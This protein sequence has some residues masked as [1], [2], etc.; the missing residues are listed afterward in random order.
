MPSAEVDSA[1]VYAAG[2]SF[3]RDLRD[4]PV[5]WSRHSSATTV[6]WLA[7]HP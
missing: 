5:S 3:D 4:V 6:P 2:L 1:T 7:P